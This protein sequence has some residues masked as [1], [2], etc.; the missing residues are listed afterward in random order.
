MNTAG[1]LPVA[2]GA[3]PLVGHAIGLLRDP[4]AFLTSLP[5]YGD[6]VQIRLGPLVVVIVCDPELTRQVLLDDRTYDKG[7]PIFDRT[8]EVFGD[9]L[10]TCPHSRHRR[11]RRLTQPAFHLTRFPGY[12]QNISAEIAA[13]TSSWRDGEILDVP[14]EMMTL[15]MRALAKTMFSSAL[16]AHCLQQAIEDISDVLAGIYRRAIMPP[17]LSRLPTPGNRR[18]RHAHS[19]L[20]RMI[21]DIIAYRTI[22][23]RDHGDL[24]SALLNSRD[25]EGLG[26]DAAAGQQETLTDAELSDQVIIF[27]AAGT[28]STASVLAW[29]LHL[30]GQH[31]EIQHRVQIETDTILAGGTARFD[32]LPELKMTGRV[33]TETLRLY[34]PGWFITRTV[35]TASRLGG[36]DLAAGTTIAYSPYL[37][38]HRSDIYENPE[39]FDPDRWDATRYPPP[40]RNGA[41]PFAAGARKCIGDQF[42]IT[43]ATLALA[44]ITARWNLQPL[45]SQ[46]RP[47]IAAVLSPQK[48]RMR[49]VARTRDRTAQTV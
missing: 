36:H 33:I 17:W 45:R 49:L 31:P 15:T 41:I 14:A 35:A 12:A 9:S 3:L 27:F 24:L 29:A 10:G 2:P 6:M 20:R 26:S 13:V 11:Q 32:H 7:G 5:N 8:R 37:I 23:S 4:L 48:L 18:Y 42:A 22:E 16:P 39:Q 47:T 40:P 25:P 28:E 43:E 46:V 38:Q 34:P 44:A 1:A 21:N 19:R 30:L